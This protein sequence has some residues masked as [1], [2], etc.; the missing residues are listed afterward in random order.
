MP[1]LAFEKSIGGAFNLSIIYIK[2]ETKQQ[3]AARATETE[4]ET[5][6]SCHQI[7]SWNHHSFIIARKKIIK[8]LAPLQR[9]LD[10]KICFSYFLVPTNNAPSMPSECEVGS[11]YA[12]AQNT[13][14]RRFI[15]LRFI[16]SIRLCFYVAYWAFII[17]ETRERKRRWGHL[18]VFCALSKAVF[19]TFLILEIFLS[20]SS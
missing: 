5:V 9:R 19:L 10:W 13:F 18:H 14:P 16:I 7:S 20:L 2:I 6:V 8:A 12:D 15:F 11:C 17:F 1:L 4:R 3:Q